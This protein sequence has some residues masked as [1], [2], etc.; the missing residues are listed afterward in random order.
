MTISRFLFRKFRRPAPLGW[1]IRCLLL[2]DSTKDLVA[3]FLS[4]ILP[5]VLAGCDWVSLIPIFA[6]VGRLLPSISKSVTSITSI[7]GQSFKV[8]YLLI[9]PLNLSKYRGPMCLLFNSSQNTTGKISH[10]ATSMNS[11]SRYHPDYP[12]IL[13]H[14][15]WAKDYKTLRLLPSLYILRPSSLPRLWSCR[16]LGV[17]GARLPTG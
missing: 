17:R 13:P 12:I 8:Q 15:S 14:G 9:C 1:E 6:L 4:N 3:F 7:S 16:I 2:T 10:N 5:G 11:P